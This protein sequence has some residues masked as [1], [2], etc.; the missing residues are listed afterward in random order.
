LVG[1]RNLDHAFQEVIP[2]RN[3]GFKD[4][5]ESA[6]RK[7]VRTTVSNVAGIENQSSAGKLEFW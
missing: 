4:T 1:K 6:S 5:Q 2:L 7:V 3:Q